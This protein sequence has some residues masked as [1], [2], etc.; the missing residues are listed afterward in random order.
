MLDWTEP[1]TLHYLS[2]PIQYIDERHYE[3]FKM[4]DIYHEAQA[5]AGLS[6]RGLWNAHYDYDFDFEVYMTATHV[7]DRSYFIRLHL[8]PHFQVVIPPPPEAGKYLLP[9]LPACL[10]VD[11]SGNPGTQVEVEVRLTAH[12]PLEKFVGRTI[13]GTF[14]PSDY[15]IGMI[16]TR[17]GGKGG[18]VLS[19]HNGKFAFGPSGSPTKQMKSGVQHL[20]YGSN[21]I[22][23][24]NWLKKILLLHNAPTSDGRHFNED[25]VQAFLEHKTPNVKQAEAFRHAMRDPSTRAP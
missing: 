18:F 20:L 4:R 1:Y 10:V 21:Y 8:S 12:G 24:N 11:H 6:D 3:V 23:A 17:S 16:V 7:A 5:E 2:A 14:G 15:D 13:P 25:A 9:M 22:P 19:D